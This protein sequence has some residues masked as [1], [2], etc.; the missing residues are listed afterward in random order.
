M[1][2]TDQALHE[3]YPH[4]LSLEL[5]ASWKFPMKKLQLQLSFFVGL[6]TDMGM[7]PCHINIVP[8]GISAGF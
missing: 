4:E 2:P 6:S 1:L 3:T 8:M 5:E 7:W